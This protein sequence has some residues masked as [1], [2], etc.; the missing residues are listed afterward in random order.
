MFVRVCRQDARVTDYNDF[1]CSASEKLACACQVKC[2]DKACTNAIDLCVDLSAPYETAAATPT[3]AASADAADGDTRFHRCAVVAAKNGSVWA[4]LKRWP[5]PRE[6]ALL[7]L[8]DA[9]TVEEA[10]VS[11]TGLL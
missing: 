4:T 9:R 10:Q 7:R 8:R 3:A 5:M 11:S 1:P 2:R 6:K